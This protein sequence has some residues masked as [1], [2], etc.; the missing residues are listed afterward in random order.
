MEG[1]PYAEKMNYVKALGNT[2]NSRND[3]K[4]AQ[5][6]LISIEMDTELIQSATLDILYA[7]TVT[8]NSEIDYNYDYG[9]GYYYYGENKGLPLVKSAAEYIAEY[10]DS[11]LT[12]SLE[13]D[14]NKN[15]IQVKAEALKDQGYIS[16]KTL[17]TLKANNYT[18][19]ITNVFKD[20]EIGKSHTEKLVTS[21][22][23]ANQGMI[24]LMK[25]I[26]RL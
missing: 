16:D 21:K 23:L 6:K 26:Q 1:N 5:E 12:C 9:T 13:N 18:I 11:E 14:I 10:L 22:L 24:I 25:T 20:I 19:F 7:I 15:W 2:I 17:E 8:N 3:F 4:K